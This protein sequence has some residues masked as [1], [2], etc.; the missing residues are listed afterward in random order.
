MTLETNIYEVT[1]QCLLIK[2]LITQRV[3][4]AENCCVIH[5][6]SHHM[7]F[8]AQVRRKFTLKQTTRPATK[9]LF[10]LAIP[11]GHSRVWTEE[12]RLCN[13]RKEMMSLR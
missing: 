13:R 12:R 9:I 5:Q 8:K 11:H 7:T 4:V 6:S 3:I 1:S 2:A 10:L